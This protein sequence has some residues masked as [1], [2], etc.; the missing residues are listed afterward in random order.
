MGVKRQSTAWSTE[1]G[2]RKV[3][4]AGTH[5]SELESRRDHE[6]AR[7]PEADAGLQEDAD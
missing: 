3:S 1:R 5:S 2:P 7:P 4:G 6:H